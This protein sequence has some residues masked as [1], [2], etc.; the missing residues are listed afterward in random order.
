MSRVSF[1][2]SCILF[3][4]AV[5]STARSGPITAIDQQNVV[6]GGWGSFSGN[7]SVGQSFTPT[8]SRVDAIE[9]WLANDS[10]TGSSARVDVYQGV[11]F[12]NLI[13]TSG[14]SV[15]PAGSAMQ[16][17][18]FD[19]VSPVALTP[20]AQYSFSITNLSG[21]IT[22]RVGRTLDNYT[23]GTYLHG[24]GNPAQFW[25]LQFVEGVHS[26]VSTVPEPSTLLLLGMGSLA[27]CGYGWRRQRKLIRMPF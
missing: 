13:G 15:V 4:S 14:N 17:V 8:L 21:F 12:S 25:D 24:N 16:K 18:H 7:T 22:L 5:A 10:A 11:G 20:A 2:C 9:L 3:A 1:V 23:G 6:A 27:V 26:P 19:L